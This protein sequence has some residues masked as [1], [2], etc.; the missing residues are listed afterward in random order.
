MAEFDVITAQNGSGGTAATDLLE[1]AQVQG[2]RR[3]T[4]ATIVADGTEANNA[5]LDVVKLPLGAYVLGAQVVVLNAG[6]TGLAT[7][8]DAGDADRYLTAIDQDAAANTITGTL[9]GTGL[10]F[11]ID[12]E[13][14]RTVTLTISGQLSAADSYRVILDWSQT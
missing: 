14:N 4:V 5:V 1:A 12:T 9:A 2:R 13:A 8:G 11:K 3:S 6:P 7:L 10:G